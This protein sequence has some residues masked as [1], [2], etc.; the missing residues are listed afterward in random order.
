[1]K[2]KHANITEKYEKT[3]VDLKDTIAKLHLIN[4]ED[5]ELEIKLNEQIGNLE[6]L[7]E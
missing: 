5:T 3:S 7:K 1:M 2:I 6:G 4:N